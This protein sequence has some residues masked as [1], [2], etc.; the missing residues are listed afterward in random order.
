MMF[1]DNIQKS[2]QVEF[3]FIVVYDKFNK[4][5][6]NSI[7]NQARELSIN[8]TAWSEKQ[9]LDQEPRLN[10]KNYV[11]F[12][13]KKLL[14]ENLSNP[15]LKVYGLTKEVKYKQQGNTV[16]IFLEDINYVEAAEKLAKSLQED[17]LLQVGT[18]IAGGVIGSSFFAVLRY[19]SKQKKAKL[20]ML[21]KAVDQFAKKRLKL[22]VEGKLNKNEVRV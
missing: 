21:Y 2:N 22:F 12:L 1:E 13:S 19:Y 15:Q 7:K 17:W 9:Y 16:G 20:Y 10:N 14:E 6:A 4:P 5:V 8:S 11:L 18:L 3:K